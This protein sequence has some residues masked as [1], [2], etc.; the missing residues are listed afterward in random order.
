MRKFI[1]ILF[2]FC[3]RLSF[4]QDLSCK[5]NILDNQIQMT[6]KHL[7]RALENA[8]MEFMNN[9]KWCLDKIQSNEKVECTIQIVLTSYDLASNHFSATAQI[10]SV[11]PVYGTSY[12][13]VLL[14]FNDENWEFD[15]QE[16]QR[17]DFN[18]NSYISNL[19]SM[20]G[21][22]AY[23]ILGLDYDSFGM[24]GGTP[25]FNKAQTVMINAQQGGL[26]GWKAFEKS[27][28]TRYNLIDNILNEQFRP[29]REA[30]YMYHRKGMDMMSKNPDEARKTIYASLELVQKVSKSFP[31]SVMM[32]MFF[33]AKSDE[34]VNI[35]KN[36][37]QSEKP[38]VIALLNEM[39]ITNSVKYEKIK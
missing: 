22:Y 39:N 9:T 4:A 15:Y 27:T 31:M 37:S 25:Y 36:A 34:L 29:I 26:A 5:V 24:L 7:F 13:S 20:M 12:N 8:L 6:D 23:F 11:R 33:E 10:Q 35:F 3:F 14:N 21:F 38:K 2:L 17:L 32:I 30:Y 1:L 28:R 18:E 16:F 19:T